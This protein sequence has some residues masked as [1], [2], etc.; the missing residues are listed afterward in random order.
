VNPEGRIDCSSCGQPV[1]AAL[2]QDSVVTGKVAIGG[3]VIEAREV[4]IHQ[5]PVEE[6]SESVK[7][8]EEWEARKDGLF[9]EIRTARKELEAP[10]AGLEVDVDQ[11][12]Q[13]EYASWGKAPENYFEELAWS[14]DNW[15][16]ARSKMAQMADQIRDQ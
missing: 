10:F 4:H 1:Q 11:I 14:R 2:I 6:K 13:Q 16:A 7:E 12:F 9:A 3:N 5:A 8:M 15:R